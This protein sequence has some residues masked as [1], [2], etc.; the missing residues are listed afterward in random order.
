VGVISLIC[1]LRT[2]LD[3][4]TIAMGCRHLAH[5]ICPPTRL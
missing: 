1:G 5:I 4:P 3:A 2:D